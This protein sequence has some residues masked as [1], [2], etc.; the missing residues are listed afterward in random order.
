VS[1]SAGAG[2]PLLPDWILRI[3]IPTPFPVGPV[4]AWLIRREPITLIDAGPETP[5]AAAALDGALLGAG[6]RSGALSRLLL[7]H[8]HHDHFGGAM[9]LVRRH[10]GL[11]ISGSEGD[12]RHF[13]FD[14]DFERF[15]RNLARSGVPPEVRL[16]ILRTL[17]RID[18]FAR[19][20]PDLSPLRGGERL[21][22]EGW[23]I[24]VL[25]TPGHTPG[26]LSYR[27]RGD[28]GTDL[29]AAGDTIL[30]R[31][32]PNAVVDADPVDP[33]RIYPSVSQQVRTLDLVEALGTGALLTGHGRAIGDV[34][35]A[36]EYQ[37]SRHDLRRRQI[38]GHLAS[39]TEPPSAWQL[40]GRLFPALDRG[41]LFL[42]YSE[43]LGN[44]LWLEERGEAARE[45]DGELER[46]R[47][48]G[49]PGTPR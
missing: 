1:P 24:E 45:V 14:R 39:S 41:E 27:I 4:N 26:S 46:W 12:R 11:R 6:L 36:R 44:L 22:G 35:A 3:P 9:G 18:R 28:D 47:V 32:T 49:E 7:T 48:G 10:P 15:H 38:L 19:P 31:I 20:I 29:L 23:S 2:P 30:D 33:E 5:E 37:R 43:V 25:A 21:E 16:E 13:S 42:G 40:V 34:P 17:E 8:G